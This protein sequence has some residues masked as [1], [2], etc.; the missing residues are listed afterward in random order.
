MSITYQCEQCSRWETVRE[1][2]VGTRARCKDCG[3]EMIVPN[4][5]DLFDDAVDGPLG[6]ASL[7][8]ERAAAP[9][10]GRPG[11]ASPAPGATARPTVG[12][13]GGGSAGGK[14]W[15]GG[16]GVAGLILFLIIRVALRAPMLRGGGRPP[17]A[18]QQIRA[19]PARPVVG[20]L[21]APIVVPRAFP[22][23]GE[24]RE[25]EPGVLLHE[26]R[27]RPDRL[28][29]PPGQSG[30]LWLYLPKPAEG[31]RRAPGSLPCVLIAPA[32][33]DLLTGMKLA[34]G[35]RPEHLPYVRAGFAVLA[36]E[37][38]GADPNAN[39]ARPSLA[40]VGAFLRA[41]AGLANGRV[42]IAFLKAQVPEVD[43][44][45]LFV[46]GHSSAATFAMLLAE[47]EASL[48]GCVAYAP[49]IDLEARFR[50]AVGGW[51]RANGLAD[52]FQRFS[53]RLGE[54]RLGCPIF[55]FHAKDDSNISYEDTVACAERLKALG[56]AVTLDLVDEGEHSDSMLRDGIPRAIAW[57]KARDAEARPNKE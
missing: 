37:L 19:N 32:G 38:D 55:L 48:R 17:R 11:P 7:P 18:P 15:G 21:D 50:G 49:A 3:H 46:A 44:G 53:P 12:P 52:L 30:T 8:R 10:T 45:R 26:V 28:P 35:D 25:V 40:S 13:A 33:S 51:L 41:K 16:F 36:F 20:D 22:D 14:A 47:N 9:A 34:P 31:A 5:P 1:G 6:G 23:L 2:R 42:A 56:K 57:L 27:L 24:A 39:R 29:A 4:T 54:P 43:P